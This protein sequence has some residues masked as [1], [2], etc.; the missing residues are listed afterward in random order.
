MVRFTL[1]A[2][3]GVAGLTALPAVCEEQSLELYRELGTMPY[4]NWEAFHQSFLPE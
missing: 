1:I 2:F 3:V 4:D